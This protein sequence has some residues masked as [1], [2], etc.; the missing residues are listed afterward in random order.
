MDK[1]AAW[2]VH[3]FTASGIIPGFFAIVAISNDRIALAFLMLLIAQVIDGIDGTLARVFRVHEV[4]PR[5]SGKMM[6]SV[7]DFATYAI[8]PAYLIYMS[9]AILPD[10]PWIREFTVSVILVVS[11]LYYGKAGMISD[12]LYFV[13]FPALWNWV[14]FYLYYIIGGSPWVN[15]GLILLF[16]FLHFVPIKYVYPSRSERLWWLNVAVTIVL[17]LSIL[18]VLLLQEALIVIEGAIQPLRV[19]AVGAMF[20]FF[21]VGV[22]QS[23]LDLRAASAD[24]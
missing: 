6:D 9:P 5:T 19:V 2:M 18:M 16:A 7:I 3:V 10:G 11:A 21:S 13:G 24:K 22:Y 12:D 4:L 1:F 23:W 20:Y 15:F 14:A 17:L 8:I